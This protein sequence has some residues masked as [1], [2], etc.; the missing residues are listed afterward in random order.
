MLINNPTL[1]NSENVTIYGRFLKSCIILI[2]L[3]LFLLPKANAQ[4][5]SFVDFSSS[6]DLK[7]V[8]G[9]TM[10]M[11]QF[12]NINLAMVEDGQLTLH[13][14][15][16]ESIRS[17]SILSLSPS[18]AISDPAMTFT[19]LQTFLVYSDKDPN[20]Q[21]NGKDIF[22][23]SSAGSILN[24]PINFT[25]N[26]GDNQ[27]AQIAISVRDIPVVA[28]SRK[29][30][31]EEFEVVVQDLRGDP[32]SLGPGDHVRLAKDA[33]GVFHLFYLDGAGD[34]TYKFF[35]SEDG[36]LNFSS[37]QIIT[38]QNLLQEPFHSLQICNIIQ[39]VLVYSATGGEGIGGE[40]S[41]KIYFQTGDSE[42]VLSEPLV[43]VEEEF[44]SPSLFCNLQG[45]MALSWERNGDL[46]FRSG[47]SSSLGAEQKAFNSTARESEPKIVIDSFA[48]LYLS[49]KRDERLFFSTNTT[50]PEASF[51]VEPVQGEAPLEVQFT[52]KSVGDILRWVW[53]FGG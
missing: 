16:G 21:K 36:T 48:N 41:E 31:G 51:T 22:V 17:Q 26:S 19:T 38:N 50:H 29:M 15:L 5:R 34:L 3:G 4:F 47:A 25:D 35:T 13:S 2:M 37:A 42:G 44:H 8:N 40:N 28:W 20:S 9:W 11:D 46:W 33:N 24:T 18:G 53:D 1:T 30:S 7:P 23:T 6:Q 27:R 49:F 52:D 14:I 45:S 32:I 43:L 39:T 12:N 10:G